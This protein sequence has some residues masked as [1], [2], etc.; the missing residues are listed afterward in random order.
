MRRR[1]DCGYGESSKA[2]KM[3]EYDIIPEIGLVV[4]CVQGH[5]SADCFLRS[6]E[7]Y[8][9]DPRKR[10]HYHFLVMVCGEVS[11]E[12]GF[13]DIWNL[14]HKLR[15]Y[16]VERDDGAKT[17]IVGSDSMSFGMARILQSLFET[18]QPERIHVT[19]TVEEAL[20]VLG[21]QPED[22]SYLDRAVGQIRAMCEQG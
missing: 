12:S 8:H 10:S 13:G 3:V 15:Q 18:A 7:E 14:S 1:W 2:G 6:Y 16:Y 5:V 21:V 11:T 20:N 9:V 17:V 22:A 19:R 4:T